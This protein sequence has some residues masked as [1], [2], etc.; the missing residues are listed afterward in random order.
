[1]WRRFSGHASL[2]GDRRR[3]SACCL[4][5]STSP[6]RRSSTVPRDVLV[7]SVCRNGMWR[8]LFGT[9]IC[10]GSVRDA[11]AKARLSDG[12]PSHRVRGKP[13]SSLC[14]HVFFTAGLDRNVS[15]A[16]ESCCLS[17]TSL[18]SLHAY[19]PGGVVGGHFPPRSMVS[20]RFE[21]SVRFQQCPDDA[22]NLMVAIAPNVRVP[23]LPLHA[24]ALACVDLSMFYFRQRAGQGIKG[25]LVVAA[26]VFVWVSDRCRARAR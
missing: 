3:S 10:E 13:H 11:A 12:K 25:D 2:M 23:T 24:P 16:L 26:D 7:A 19:V 8:S 1:M 9:R 15:R 4:C 20:V 5:P 18:D 17:A 6:D 14:E 22:G 21:S